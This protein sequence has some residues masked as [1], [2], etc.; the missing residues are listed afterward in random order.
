MKLSFT[1][2]GSAVNASL[3]SKAA[4]EYENRLK[5]FAT[6]SLHRFPSLQAFRTWLN[7]ERQI[8]ASEVILLDSRG[9]Q[10]SSEDFST[11]I[12][13]LQDS[14]KRHIVFAIGPADGWTD[15][16]RIHANLLLSL[17]PMTLPHQ[18]AHLVLLEQVYRAFTIASGH[19]YHSGH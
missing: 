10:L 18:L 2:I 7:R 3:F 9:K 12:T 1:H 5:H 6:P 14:G 15:A 17:S 19:P 4:V 11:R 8:P 16:D 13:H